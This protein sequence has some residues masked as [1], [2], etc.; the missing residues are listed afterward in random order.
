MAATFDAGPQPASRVGVPTLSWWRG[1]YWT[2]LLVGFALYLLAM[3]TLS[4]S[5][6]PNLVPTVIV[7]GAFL[8]P[9][10]YVVFLYE[11]DALANVSP[12]TVALTFFFGGVLGTISAQ[13]LEE[14][15]VLGTG[16]VGMLAVGFSE[17]VAKLVAIVWL[18][19]QARYRSTLHGVVFGAAAGMGFAAFESMG[20]GFTYLLMSRGNLDVL[21]EVLLNRGLLS[22]LGHGTWAAIVAGVIWRERG[23]GRLRINRAVLR[24]FVGVVV[25]HGLW[26]WTVG[27]IPIELE[28]PG[29]MLQWRFVDVMIPGIGLPIPGLIL[30]LISLWI[31]G[32]L[33]RG[34]ARQRAAVAAAPAVAS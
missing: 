11:H 14:R 26:D 30:G 5:G 31:L 16:L 28:L 29:L 2:V 4:A 3:R 19:G 25:L 17:E 13:L 8:V 24:A 27:A 20:Y 12:S 21:G 10:T 32:R 23:A 6:N 9:V 18:L 15:L 34:A 1:S 33:I 22:P 7:L